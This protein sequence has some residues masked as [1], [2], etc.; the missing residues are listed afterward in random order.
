MLRVTYPGGWI[1]MNN[2]KPTLV[3]REKP[4]SPEQIAFASLGTIGFERYCEYCLAYS[5]PP[6]P[7][8]KA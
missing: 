1:A 3:L 6:K 5:E 2:D 4:L 7:R 8:G